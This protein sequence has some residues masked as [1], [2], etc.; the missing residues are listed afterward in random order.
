MQD[1]GLHDLFCCY[2]QPW[3]EI[4]WEINPSMVRI[5]AQS[6]RFAIRLA[7]VMN[8]GLIF[9]EPTP[10]DGDEKSPQWFTSSFVVGTTQAALRLWSTTCSNSFVQKKVKQRSPVL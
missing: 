2:P 7:R 8:S 5:Q 6:N 10:C 9:A 4:V 3:A 1:N